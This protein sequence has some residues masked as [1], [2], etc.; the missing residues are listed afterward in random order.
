VAHDP[1]FVYDPTRADFQA[2]AHAIYETLRNEHPVYHDP[3]RDMWALSRYADVRDA[4]TD[5]A[6]LSSENTEI[7]VGLIPQ[8]QSMDPPRHDALRNI[9]SRAFT[10]R[11]A[12]AMEGRIRAI[13]RELLDAF[14]ERDEADLMAEFARHLPSRVIGTTD[15]LAA[16]IVP[17]TTAPPR[18]SSARYVNS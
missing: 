17:L 6:N 15:S 1:D 3:V 9:V 18:G 12:D 11:R 8:I 10:G 4:A 14:A 13:A 5:T 2:N 16:S 7:S